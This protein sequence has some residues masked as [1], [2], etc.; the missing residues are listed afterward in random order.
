MRCSSGSGSG[1]EG[2]GASRLRDGGERFED[3]GELPEGRDVFFSRWL[4]SVVEEYD[5]EAGRTV[6][7]SVC[8]ESGRK[9]L[10]S[11]LSMFE[12]P[13]VPLV[14]ECDDWR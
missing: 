10:E 11:E 7:S 4:E 2:T 14:T 1:L 12:T 9:E 3:A 6:N 8:S 13:G 5:S